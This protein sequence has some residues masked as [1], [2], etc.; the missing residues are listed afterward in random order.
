MVFSA[1]KRLRNF[2]N[3]G[4]TIASLFES[5]GRR[6]S[7]RQNSSRAGER[8][9]TLFLRS[10]AVGPGHLKAREAERDATRSPLVRFTKLD[11]VFEH[12]A[13]G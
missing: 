10:P 2:W 3:A 5:G 7:N 6:F 1:T 9:D 11:R 8:A 4:A 12:Y 13:A